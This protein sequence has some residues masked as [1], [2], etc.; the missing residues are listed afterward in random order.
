LNKKK[1]G[2]YCKAY[3]F[4]DV[5]SLPGSKFENNKKNAASEKKYRRVFEQPEFG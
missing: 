1:E 4:N 3:N 2:N 5:C